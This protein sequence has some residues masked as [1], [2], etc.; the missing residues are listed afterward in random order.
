MATPIFKFQHPDLPNQD[1]YFIQNTFYELPETI[2]MDL[3]SFV[4]YHIL[5]ERTLEGFFCSWDN[6]NNTGASMNGIDFET[7]FNEDEKTKL[8]EDA[9]A[10]N[11]LQTAID[12]KNISV[13]I[14]SFIEEKRFEK[15]DFEAFVNENAVLA[16]KHF[17][18]IEYYQS[19]HFLYDY[20]Q[21][22]MYNQEENEEED[23]ESDD[24]GFDTD[25]MNPFD[26]SEIDFDTLFD[27]D[28][29][30]D[31]NKN[32]NPKIIEEYSESEKETIDSIFDSLFEEDEINLE[33]ITIANFDQKELLIKLF[34]DKSLPLHLIPHK[35]RSSGFFRDEFIRNDMTNLL[36]N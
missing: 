29:N 12:N 35:Y 7:W 26:V 34:I 16:F 9:L 28:S 22:L 27:I 4:I 33:D 2:P 30:N 8:K 23:N 1:L 36:P 6:L 15:E 25:G 21:S 14:N 10:S 32:E 20:I 5:T 11:S 13:K 24:L 31:S 19:R 18:P 17:K 3:T